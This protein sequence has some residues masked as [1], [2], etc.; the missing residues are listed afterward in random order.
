MERKLLFFDIDGTLL[1]GGFPGY[2]PAGSL[3]ALERA[4]ENGHS[5]FI[6]TGRT[7]GLMP[8]SVR[9][10]PFDGYICGCGSHILYRGREIY[11]HRIPE[12]IR[13][14]MVHIMRRT[15]IQGV[16]EGAD[17]YYFEDR[18]DPLPLISL[19]RAVCRQNS[20]SIKT[21][22]FQDPDLDYDKFIITCDENSDLPSFLDQIRDDFDFIDQNILSGGFG[23]LIPKGCSKAAGIDMVVDH[24]G[25]SLDDCYVFGDSSNDLAMLKHVKHSIAMGNSSQDV[26]DVSSYVTTPVYRDGI[27]NALA[28]LRLI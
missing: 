12:S 8:E 1:A 21:R 20:S 19:L 11:H 10:F 6:N 17:C 13:R 3:E 22:T 4:R 15:G 28:H 25:A 16:Y 27:K 7:Y 9:R 5:L 23:E 24:L 26:L 2:I 14:D 18:P